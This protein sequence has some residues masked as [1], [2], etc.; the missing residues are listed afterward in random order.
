[1]NCTFSMVM[2][3]TVIAIMLLGLL[4]FVLRCLLSIA[5][6]SIVHQPLALSNRDSRTSGSVVPH[7]RFQLERR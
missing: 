3:A 4:F 1:M 7:A 6:D 5:R 2:R